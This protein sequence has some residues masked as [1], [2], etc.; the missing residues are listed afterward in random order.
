MLGAVLFGAG[1]GIS[2]MCPGPALVNLVRPSAPI[3][4]Y[5]GSMLVGMFINHKVVGGL[6]KAVGLKK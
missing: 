1:W 5:V 4:S 3:L 6:L 2:G